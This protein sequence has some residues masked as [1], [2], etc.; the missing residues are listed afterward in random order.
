[1]VTRSHLLPAVTDLNSIN[2]ADDRRINRTVLAAKSHPR[3][4]SLNDQN[5]FVNPGPHRV[6]HD[7]MAFF[8]LS[9]QVD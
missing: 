2:Y 8:V 4:A 5:D 9:V 1:M 3:G 7:D 6:N